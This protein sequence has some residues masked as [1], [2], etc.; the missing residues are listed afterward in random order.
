MSTRTVVPASHNAGKS[1]PIQSSDH[2]N[3]VTDVVLRPALGVR[4]F[5]VLSR[6]TQLLRDGGP[7]A[8]SWH[9]QAP[10]QPQAQ[11]E[12]SLML[13][14]HVLTRENSHG[15]HLGSPRITNVD[16]ISIERRFRDV[17]ARLICAA[18][19]F[20]PQFLDKN[21]QA[22]LNLSQRAAYTIE[23]HAYHIDPRDILRLSARPHYVDSAGTVLR[24]G[25][26]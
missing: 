22:W 3:C 8:R 2:D 19:R 13:L 4:L 21:K 1:Q 7:A 26:G 12:R 10:S 6:H 25:S 23:T 9:E 20:H 11:E 15:R 16:S 24:S 14:G 5:N 17:G 18:G